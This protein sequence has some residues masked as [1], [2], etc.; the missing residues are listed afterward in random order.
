MKRILFGLLIG[1]WVSCFSTPAQSQVVNVVARAK[2]SGQILLRWVPG[3]ETV[4]QQG[5]QSGYLIERTTLKRN[6]VLLGTPETVSLT[7]QPLKPATTVQ[8]QPYLLP[9]S[10]ITR[11]CT[12]PCMHPIQ[13]FQWI[14]PIN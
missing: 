1:F 6:G 13:R 5:N 4:W 2:P 7:P 9:D 3:N 10:V 8:W 11:R 12:K 14:R